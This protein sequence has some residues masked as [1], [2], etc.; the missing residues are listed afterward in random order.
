MSAQAEGAELVLRLDDTGPGIPEAQRERI[1]EPF[2][3]TKA[4]GSGLGLPLVHTVVSQHGG[5]LTVGDAPAG[6][7]RFTLRLPLSVR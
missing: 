1:F 5:S 4:Q 6:G 2:F 7:A 3:T